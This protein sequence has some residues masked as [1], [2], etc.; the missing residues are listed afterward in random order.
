MPPTTDLSLIS[1]ILPREEIVS[2]WIQRV[3]LFASVA[4]AA[5]MIS[6]TG[7]FGDAWQIVSASVYGAALILLYGM[8]A[9]YHGTHYPA[10]KRVLKVLDHASIYVLIAGT[11]TPFTLVTLNGAWGWSLFGVTWGMAAIG[12][13]WKLW[14]TNR[15]AVVS[16]LIYLAMGWVGVVAAVPLIAVL[17]VGGLVWLVL[18]G[19]AYSVGTLFFLWERL[20]YHVAIWHGFVMLGVGCHYGAILGYVLLSG[21]A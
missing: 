7:V 1:G 2:A 3:M 15:F 6:L 8:S 4:A 18:G 13:L 19:V 21:G 11:Y 20:P 17:P 5:V 10:R 12:I 16:T 14:F 9:W